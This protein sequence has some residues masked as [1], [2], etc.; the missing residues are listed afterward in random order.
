[1]LPTRSS[2]FEA[3]GGATLR[4]QR[5]GELEWLIDVLV[6]APGTVERLGRSPLVAPAG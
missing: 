2:T 4:E 1:M 3:A 5:A 6:F